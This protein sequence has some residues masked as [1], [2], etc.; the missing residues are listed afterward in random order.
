MCCCRHVAEGGRIGTGT[1]H[2]M[3]D[4]VYPLITTSHLC[5]IWK[6]GEKEILVDIWLVRENV[7]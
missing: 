3:S 6:G 5:L 4:S 7:T 1:S 2:S